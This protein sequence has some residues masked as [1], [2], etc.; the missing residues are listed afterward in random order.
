MTEDSINKSQSLR[1]YANFCPN[2]PTSDSVAKKIDFLL[3]RLCS[4]GPVLK[5]VIYFSFL[6]K[7]CPD[8]TIIARDLK[9]SG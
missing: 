1:K 9:F 5:C 3:C 6:R 4:S 8:K 2:I 7:C